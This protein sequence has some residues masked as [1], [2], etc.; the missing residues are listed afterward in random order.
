MAAISDRLRV[1]LG[2]AA[3]RLHTEARPITAAAAATA[4]V[5]INVAAIEASGSTTAAVAV[6]FVGRRLLQELAR[7]AR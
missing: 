3:S 2:H 6:A 4:T 1:L 7:T 5:I